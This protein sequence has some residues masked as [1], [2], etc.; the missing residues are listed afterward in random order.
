[1]AN[2]KR[3]TCRY[4]AVHARRGSEVSWRARNNLKPVRVPDYP[5]ECS[6]DDWHRVWQERRRLYWSSHKSPMNN[7]PA[8][9]D[10]T[11]HTRPH[12]TATKRLELA[13][14]R[15]ADPDAIAWPLR[16]KPHFY[17]W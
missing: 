4:K 17:Y 3:R 11:F 10:R 12:R 1:M 13:V 2:Y 15:G 9:W 7:W 8:W 5:S 14:L 6:W 16:H